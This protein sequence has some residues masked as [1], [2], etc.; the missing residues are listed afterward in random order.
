[1]CDRL[2]VLVT[3]AR[4]AV[5]SLDALAGAD[6][7][8]AFE[9]LSE[10]EKLAAAGK[11]LLAPKIAQSETWA[12]AG[13][14]SPE[15][16]MARTSGTSMGAAKAAVETGKR[17]E[18]LPATASAVKSGALSLA[19]A[20]AVA[21]AAAANAA[22]EEQL[23]A[24]AATEDLRG[25]QRQARKVVLDSRGTLEER[26][27]RQRKLRDFSHWIDDEGMTAGRFRLTPEVGAAVINKLQAE[28]DRQYRQAYRE[29]R[30]ETPG[31]YA[32]D[33]FAA[34]VTGEGLIGTKSSKGS[35]VVVVVSREALLRGEANSEAGE[36]CEVPGFGAV[37]VSVAKAMLPDAFLKGVVVDGTRV[38]HVKHFGRHRSAEID[39]AL[40]IRTLLQ[41]GDVCCDVEGCGRTDIQWDHTLDFAKGGETSEPN[42][43]PLC[44]FHH[45]EKTAGRLVRQDGRWVRVGLVAQMRTPP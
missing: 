24:A 31:N 42:L 15:E 22:S 25:L 29:G 17:L 11:V 2:S 30:R 7:A 39:T 9:S 1:M 21:E 14:H 37:P 36:L 28:T 45:R 8:R 4:A 40:M 5:A 27:A 34:L 35:E 43:R 32:A 41:Q 16:W 13:H 23:L 19:Q 18:Q 38:S 20:A 6:A 33:A 3:S 44:R 10:L 26:Y 12:R